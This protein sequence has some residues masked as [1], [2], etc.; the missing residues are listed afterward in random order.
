MYE[1]TI[2]HA[3][4][5]SDAVSSVRRYPRVIDAHMHWYPQEF[6]DLMIKKG[7]RYG[8]QMGE[9]KNGNPV[10]LSVPD[11]TQTSVMRKTMTH[12]D[13]IIADMKKR[14]CDTYALSM[15]NPLM[16]WAPPEFGLELCVAH[17]D[18][19]VAAHN[20][21]PDKFYGSIILPM[22]D[23]G[24]AVKELERA[25]KFPCMRTVFIAEHILGKN[26]HEK[27]FWP[28]YE[29]AEGLGLSLTL[30]NLYP[31]GAERMKDFFMINTLG[32]PQEAGYAAM[33]LVCGGV[34]D[35]FPKLEVFLPHAGGTF[36][37][38]VG[39]LDLARSVS[40]ELSHMKKSAYDYL[41]RFHYDLITH[42][43]SVM[44]LLIDMVGAD[45]IVAGT[46]FPQGMSVKQP[47]DFVESIPGLTHREREMI[48]CDNPAR[49]LG[50]EP[51]LPN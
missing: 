10:V 44:R 38:L 41:R 29:R 20:K 6:V 32:N 37:F 18:A 51:R 24:L 14:K 8:A 42:D 36:P 4:I 16:Y 49:L 26:L 15:T 33:S 23:V 25:A 30:T 48:L 11:G 21:H 19:C 1:D 47:V 3:K 45:R 34:M 43:T 2:T 27:E 22:Q 12:L 35:A 46:D 9:D 39:R 31:T 13:D 17:N 7:P 28:I 50:I 40:K 5:D